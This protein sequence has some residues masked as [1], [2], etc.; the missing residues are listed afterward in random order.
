MSVMNLKEYKESVGELQKQATVVFLLDKNQ[1]RI[2]LAMKK[3]GF[4][5]GKWNGIGGKRNEP[6]TIEE[7]A[8]RE[9]REEICVAVNE[10][11]QMAIL[12]FYFPPNPAFNQQ[13]IVFLAETWNGE[14]TETEEMKPEWYDI[15]QIPYNE[16][17]ADDEIWLPLVLSGKEVGADFLFGDGDKLIEYSIEN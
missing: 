5:M 15:S 11:T 17:W 3:R 1:N 16:M 9:T 4:G 10:M 7:T 14:P 6:E 2:L 8:K 13:V 12:N